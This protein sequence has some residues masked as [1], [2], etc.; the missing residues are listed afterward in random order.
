[1]ASTLTVPPAHSRV[2]MTHGVPASPKADVPGKADN[3]PEG[4]ETKGLRLKEA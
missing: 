3:S 1:M 2:H 4:S